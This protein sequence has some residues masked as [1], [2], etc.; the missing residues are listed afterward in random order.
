[1]YVV[2]LACRW[3]IQ[4]E[5]T[6]HGT[7]VHF[8][9]SDQCLIVLCCACDGTFIFSDGDQRTHVADLRHL[10]G[11]GNQ[12]REECA[13]EEKRLEIEM[14]DGRGR[15]KEA[16]KRKVRINIL[17]FTN[18]KYYVSYE[19]SEGEEGGVP[20]LLVINKKQSERIYNMLIHGRARRG[21]GMVTHPQRR[22]NVDL[23]TTT[24]VDV[25]VLIFRARLF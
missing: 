4:R 17:L 21:R 11:Q 13:D 14:K 20:R 1:M 7:T 23:N 16:E 6:A 18:I 3:R 2:C 5:T 19:R 10:K 9:F 25:R 8:S 12:P 24:T 22:C 15:E